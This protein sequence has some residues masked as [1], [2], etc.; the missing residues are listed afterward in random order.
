MKLAKGFYGRKKSN[1]RRGS[2]AV[3]RALV[4]SYRDRK[5]RKREF[6]RLW[7]LRINAAVR[8]HDLTYSQ[9]V[10][11]L[12]KAKIGLNRKMLSQLA[13]ESP[14]KESS[15]SCLMPE[16][17]SADRL[18]EQLKNIQSEALQKLTAQ[19]FDEKQLDAFR[20]EYLGRQG[21]LTQLLRDL[22]GVPSEDRPRLGQLANQIKGHL[23]QKIAS[24]Q[25][26]LKKTKLEANLASERLDISL[27]ER[28]MERG[29]FHPVL[30]TMEDA[31]EILSRYGFQVAE[32]PEIESDYYNFE[33]LNIPKDHPSRDMQDTFY[34]SEEQVLRTHTSPVQVRVM[35]KF[36]PPLRVISP[37]VVYRHD[38]DVSHTP[39]F[40]QIEGLMVDKGVSMAHLKGILTS[41][42][43]KLFSPR[44]AIRFRPSY[45]PFT[46]PSAELDIACVI[47]DGKGCRVCKHSGWLEVI[48]CGMVH[49]AV[50]R[51][52]NYNTE[53]YTGFAFGMGIERIA[54]LR[55]G[56][57]DIRLFFEND[58]RFL[59]QF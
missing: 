54:M 35:E 38:H 22:K 51:N 47:C 41:F 23:V 12:A 46:E 49:P 59:R 48:G 52:I 56:I 58:L 15:S 25:A 42:V 28:P 43:H 14:K 36:K 37:G 11:R 13:I 5:N 19:T 57:D 50:F 2:E 44:T 17:L 10:H 21:K 33:A 40:H 9:F 55:Y 18:T 7:V 1:F 24:V 53:T 29:T 27:P 39:M 3:E 6:R 30:K 31:V 16:K 34:I 26:G 8:A 4:F 20:L 45:F 32:G